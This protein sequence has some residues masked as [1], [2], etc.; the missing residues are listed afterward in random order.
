MLRILISVVLLVQTAVTILETNK[1]DTNFKFISQ[2]NLFVITVLF[3]TMAVVQV[4]HGRRLTRFRMDIDTSL[5]L[6]N[7][8]R[9]QDQVEMEPEVGEEPAID[10]PWNFWKWLIPMYISVLCVAIF[11]MI[12]FWITVIKSTEFALYIGDDN[13]IIWDLLPTIPAALMLIEW[14]FNMI[15]IDWP[16]LL[17]VEMLF[18]FYIFLNFLIVT[19]DPDH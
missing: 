3:I 8:D 6:N 10:Q 4:Q 14:P 5:I 19:I 18:T 1:H 11:L 7:E 17:F 12:D 13:K 16:M 15:P 9:H 2:W